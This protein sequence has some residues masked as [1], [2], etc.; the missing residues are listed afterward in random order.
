MVNKNISI[1]EKHGWRTLTWI[2]HVYH[3]NDFLVDY[4]SITEK[5]GS[6]P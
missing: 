2:L 1:L 6:G 3:M 4:I 5:E